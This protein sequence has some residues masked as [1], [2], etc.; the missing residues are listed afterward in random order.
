MYRRYSFIFLLILIS[1]NL[2]A[3]EIEKAYPYIISADGEIIYDH[4]E[5]ILTATENARFIIDDLEINADRLMIFYREELILAE[6]KDLLFR[7]GEDLFRGKE[8]EYNY[9]EGTGVIRG[10]AT[11]LKDL[12]IAGKEIRL[13]ETENY[14]LQEVE[15]SP[16]ILPEPHYSIKAREIIVYPGEKIQ[17]RN[18][19]FYFA[20]K[21]F[22]YL[23]AYTMNYDAE[24]DKYDSVFPITDL[25]Y[26]SKGGFF[27][28]A[29]YPYEIGENFKGEIKGELNQEG[30]KYL[31]MDNFY[32]ISPALGI[33]NQYIYEDSFDTAGK[34]VENNHIGAAL[35]YN[36]SGLSFSTGIKKD[37][38]KDEIIGELDG[39]YR[40]GRF[41]YGYYNEFKEEGLSKEA[42]SI[43]YR[44]R[45]PMQLIYRNGYSIDYLPY[46]QISSPNY[47]LAGINI[48]S[49]LGIGKVAHKGISSDRLRLDLNLARP[50]IRTE[51]LNIRADVGIQGNYYQADNNIRANYSYYKIAVNSSYQDKLTENL[52][53]SAEL[54]YEYSMDQGQ[55]YIAADKLKTG[56][57]LRPSLGISFLQPEIY[58]AWHLNLNGRYELREK[59]LEKLELKIT[60]E[61]DCF[62][63]FISLDLIDRG[64]GVG[65]N[66]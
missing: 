15:L 47:H 20:G 45:Y 18:I 41:T 55:A 23:P 28:Q 63:Y 44:S 33:R 60:R 66:F 14:L 46:F 32:S 4:Q 19:W 5:G 56:E 17:A 65:I 59:A 13:L 58:S 26:S 6:G 24:K 37:Y 9:K 62:D 52:A 38:I 42:Y 10:P 53:Y 21:R 61:H 12:S 51:K 49:S 22:F 29:A 25:G 31:E 2:G 35:L 48:N 34:P 30:G 43:D 27:I 1:F 7:V 64:I 54:N 8:L 40:R 39:R 11:R 57:S 3:A 16:C 50:L 36:N